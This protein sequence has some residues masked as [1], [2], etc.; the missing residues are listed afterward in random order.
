MQLNARGDKYAVTLHPNESCQCE[1]LGT[2]WHI[3]GAKLSICDEDG[4]GK[5]MYNLKQ[6]CRNHRKKPNQKQEKRNQ[7]LV[8]TTFKKL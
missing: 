1:A 3:I 7:D 6:L 8:T 4:K 2:G 5:K